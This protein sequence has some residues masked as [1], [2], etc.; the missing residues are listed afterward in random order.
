MPVMIGVDPHKASHTA[1]ALNEHGQ[2]LDQQRVPA[3]LEGT[4]CCERG[5]SA[6]RSAAGRWRAPMASAGR[7]P[8]SW[9]ATASRSLTCRPS[10]PPGCESC[11]W[12]TVARATPTTRY[13][14][15]S[16]PKAPLSAAGRHRGP[17]DGA[18]L[19]D[20]AAPGPG[21]RPHPDHQPAPPAAGRPDPR[22]RQT[23]P[24]RQPCRRAARPGCSDRRSGGHPLGQLAGEL[25]ADVRHLEQRIAAVEARI[26]AAVTKSNTSLV[27]LFGVGPVVAATFLGEVG[28]IGRF[29]ASTTSPPTPAPPRWRPQ[30]A[31]S[32]A[33]GCPVLGTGS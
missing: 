28:D 29:P 27:Q 31:R 12:G 32:S 4:R 8:S 2:L 6:G 33:T 26:K 11:Q 22:R 24:H 1:A 30:A 9:S 21:R 20:Q 13:R 7:W 17:G 23:Q 19:A 3:T 10:W 15:Q 5:R 14:S 18:A 16:P 25:V